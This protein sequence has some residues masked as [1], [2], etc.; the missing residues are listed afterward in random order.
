[1]T[2]DN[3]ILLAAWI[4]SFGLLGVVLVWYAQAE[5]A[6]EKL[7]NEWVL[8]PTRDAASA[9]AGAGPVAAQFKT[10]SPVLFARMCLRCVL[11]G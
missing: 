7:A 3:I 6:Q 5:A 8:I 4:A 10:K 11:A 9:D 2:I 1:M